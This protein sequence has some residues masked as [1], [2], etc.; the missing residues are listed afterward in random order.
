MLSTI[1][2]SVVIKTRNE[3]LHRIWHGTGLTGLGPHPAQSPANWSTALYSWLSSANSP[4][5]LT[6]AHLC[7]LHCWGSS[8]M[9]PPPKSSPKPEGCPLLFP[10]NYLCPWFLFHLRRRWSSLRAWTSACFIRLAG[11]HWDQSDP[12]RATPPLA[13]QALLSALGDRPGCS[14]TPNLLSPW[15]HFYLTPTLGSDSG[16]PSGGYLFSPA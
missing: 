16:L 4:P 2:K 13:H 11:N 14:L 9:L 1:S 5:P 10:Y 7:H 12:P 15:S 8:K 6:R 3:F